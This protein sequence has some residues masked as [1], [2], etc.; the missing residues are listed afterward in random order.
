[1]IKN[2]C[3]RINLKNAFSFFSVSLL[4]LTAF[5]G[6]VSADWGSPS[7]PNNVPTDFDQ[8]IL[9]MT[10]WVLGFVASIAVMAII[11]GGIL[12]LTSAGDES[13]AET[14]K[15]TIKNGLLGLVICGIAYAIVVI[16][17]ETIL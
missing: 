1:M 15:K 13:Q 8:A 17:V 11:W 6:K 4:V 16:I 9:N 2:A 5:A 12:Y 7:K 10:N 3:K 14:G